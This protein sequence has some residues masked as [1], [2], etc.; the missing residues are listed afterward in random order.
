MIVESGDPDDHSR[1]RRRQ[2]GLAIVA[3][4]IPAFGG[5]APVPQGYP[6]GG[7][8]GT[9]RSG[10]LDERVVGADRRD[11]QALAPEIVGHLLD[12]RRRR[13]K[14]RRELRRP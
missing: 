13:S 10:G 3:E 14:E 6:K 12:L 2:H 11:R 5:I 1:D 9:R 4:E 7:L 8:H